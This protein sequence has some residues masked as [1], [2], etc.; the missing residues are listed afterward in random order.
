[1][2][3]TELVFYV[4]H[5][6]YFSLIYYITINPFEVEADLNNIYKLSSYLKEKS[7]RLLYKYKL[8]NTV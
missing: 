8:F 2:Y 6:R 3:G 7:T 1:M 4:V 5:E